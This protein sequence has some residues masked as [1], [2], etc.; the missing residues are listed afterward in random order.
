M[1]N[2]E[3][4]TR[5]ANKITIEFDKIKKDLVSVHIAV[6]MITKDIFN[7]FRRNSLTASDISIVVGSQMPT[8]LVVFEDLHT[9][10]REGKLKAKVFIGKF[11]HPKLYVFQ[12]KSSWIAFVGSGNFTNGG[13][14]KNEELF[15]VI[16]NTESC[17]LLKEKID[18]WFLEAKVID[19]RF[20]NAYRET[21]QANQEL[22]NQRKRNTKQLEDKINST[23]NIEN[24]DF[25]GQFFSRNHH[26]AFG[27]GK[28]ILES[29]EVLLERTAVSSRLHKLN[30]RLVKK[31]PSTWRIHPHFDPN[32]VVAHVENR[33]HHDDRVDALWVGYGRNKVDLK[34]YGDENT[35]PLYFMRMQVIVRYS[36][37]GVWLM[38]GKVAAGEIDRGN[39]S[40]QM[41]EIKY[42]KKFYDLL[43]G[44]GPLYFIEIMGDEK[45]ANYFS[46]SE[47]LWEYTQKDNWRYEYFIIG[48]N[49]IVG[50]PELKEENIVQTVISDY[51]KFFP[52]Y[53]MIRDKTFD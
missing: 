10:N 3:N 52:L 33:H 49:Y 14:G 27:P 4:K 8:P 6:G 40:R 24:I 5:I 51:T 45:P 53:E 23:F 31:I 42:R 26:E 34:K 35:T 19:E 37:V 29:P 28:P 13:W 30:D 18:Q 11:F 7:Y 1:E 36:D 46:D 38:P 39:F 50:S 12:L 21:I 48:R 20:L 15:V 44:L 9:A 17:I 2:P 16:E 47:H 43:N 32:Y 25:T 22:E 41:Q